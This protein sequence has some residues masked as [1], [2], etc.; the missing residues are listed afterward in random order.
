MYIQQNPR[1]V[2][3]LLV[4][5]VL[6]LTPGQNVTGFKP[7]YFTSFLGEQTITLG[8]QQKLKLL[9]QVLIHT[10]QFRN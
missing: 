6:L 3:P 4:Y 7:K 10:H 5:F 2:S 8:K 9:Y 1:P